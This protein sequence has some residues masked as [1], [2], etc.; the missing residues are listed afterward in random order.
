L[1]QDKGVWIVKDASA[2]KCGVITSSY[3][4]LSGLILGK[5]NFI[6]LKKKLA[7]EVLD[8]LVERASKEADWLFFQYKK[9]KKH[10]TELTEL[11]SV[12]INDKNSDIAAYIEKHPKLV[13]RKIILD[14]LPKTFKK[15]KPEL[16]EKLPEDYKKAIVSVELACR[17]VYKSAQDLESEIKSVL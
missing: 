5:D 3:E 8:I 7:S 2:N 4:I 15:Q 10:L 9:T 1:I 11:L 6:K 12:H 14:H 17:I 16:I 13:D